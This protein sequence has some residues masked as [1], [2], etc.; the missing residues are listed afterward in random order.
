MNDIKYKK[1]YLLAILLIL[2]PSIQ[3]QELSE[4]Y[5]E[6]LPPDIKQ[7]VLKRIEGK[8]NEEEKVY[9]SIDATSDLEKTMP[10]N[11]LNEFNK[12]TKEE[13]EEEDPDFGLFGKDFFDT[14]Q[15]SFMPINIP[16]LDD[17]YI[18]DFGDVLQIQLIGQ[19]DSNEKYSISR[20][21]SI[22]LPGIGKLYVSG[23][24]LMEANDLVQTKISNTY[25]GEK[26]FVTL[27]NIR[28]V[29]V[30]VSGDAYNPGVYT[31][32]GSSNMLHALY[33]AG[34]ISQYGSYREIKLIRAN[35]V[36]ETLDMY[37]IL[38]EGK[39]LSQERLRTGDIIFVAPRHNVVTVD[40]AFKRPSKYELFDEQSLINAVEYANG[41][42]VDADF[43]NIYLNRILNANLEALP[44]SD[45]PQFAEIIVQ[46]G[47]RIFVRKHSFRSVKIGGSV[48]NPGI[49]LMKEGDTVFDLI[50][51][52]GGYTQNA[53]PL[54]AVYLNKNAEEIREMASQVLYEEFVDNLI[55]L[56][57][58]GAG[59]EMDL[60]SL[61]SLAQDI[62]NTKPNG[63]VVINLEDDKNNELY[64]RNDDY[65]FIPEK[66]NNVFVFGEVTNEG[67][68]LFKE[69]GDIKHYL[70]QSAGMKETGDPKSIYV[71]LPNGN[72]V[73]YSLK[74]NLFVNQAKDIEIYRGSVIFVPRGINNSATNRL[75]AQAYAT[76]LGNIGV[77]LASISVLND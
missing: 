50:D 15:T 56:M 72:T 4:A 47:D 41:T 24:S 10:K 14:M 17:S 44:V 58:T 19:N 12:K 45:V 53:Y 68:V 74:R 5:L 54:G 22:I 64:V 33:V 32:S 77:T 31:L 40:G 35:K 9:R 27:T 67:A 76:I 70:D 55:Q 46:D 36:I 6:S 1:I 34:G 16:N 18:L 51:K 66:N 49:Y 39:F 11:Q 21:G 13:L 29:S 37:D 71:L 65:L 43:S 23:L 57:E 62:K 2:M 61:I 7:D 63:R 20:D 28:D 26:S 73:R 8:N 52:A 69:G 75:T 60:S 59:N 38:I 48:L 25:I 30:L 42:T 3:A